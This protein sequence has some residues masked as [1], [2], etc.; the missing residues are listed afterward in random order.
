MMK[1]SNEYACSTRLSEA[2]PEMYALLRVFVN[3]EAEAVL[4]EAKKQAR[5]LIAQ[6]DGTEEQ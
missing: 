2:A 4:Q 3:I 1:E 5:D 6:I